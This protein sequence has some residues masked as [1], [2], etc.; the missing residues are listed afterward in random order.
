MFSK[1]KSLCK[2]FYKSRKSVA[3]FVLAMMLA[4]SAF[5]GT[6]IKSEAAYTTSKFYFDLSDFSQYLKDYDNTYFY[7][8]KATSHHAHGY[9]YVD[10]PQSDGSSYRK[11]T[12]PFVLEGN[13]SGS[14]YTAKYVAIF[15]SLPMLCNDTDSRSSFCQVGNI[16][17]FGLRKSDNTQKF[18]Y[19][20]LYS[21]DGINWTI[22]RNTET[23]ATCICTSER[24]GLFSFDPR[25]YYVMAS[26]PIRQVYSGEACYLR[27]LSDAEIKD[28]KNISS[29]G[30][31]DTDTSGNITGGSST[32][33]GGSGSSGSGSSGSNTEEEKGFFAS[34]KESL[35]N[36]LTNIKELPSAVVNVPT[37]MINFWKNFIGSHSIGDIITAIMDAPSNIFNAWKSFFGSHTFLE[38]LNAV[39]NVPATVSNWWKDNLPSVIQ[40]IKDVPSTV[41]GWWSD[42]LPEVL[43]AIVDTPTTVWNWWKEQLPDVV[44]AIIESPKIVLSFWKDFFKEHSFSDILQAIADAPKDILKFW[45]NL[46]GSDSIKDIFKDLLDVPS[47][48]LNFWDD[49]I[50]GFIE[51]V[52]SKFTFIEESKSNIQLII[53]RLASMSNPKPPVITLPF[54]KTVMSKYGVGDIEMTFEW[55]APYHEL[56]MNVESACLYVAFC[57]RNFFDVKNMLNATSGASNVVTRL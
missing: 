40:A 4:F 32:V 46:F 56:L 19:L 51:S 41:S 11:Q 25:D 17:N 12:Y 26:Y 47:N 23:Y 22:Y 6:G 53:D 34:V 49:T 5:M 3:S 24:M 39:K 33:I 16:I 35:V 54:S 9:R 10:I 38:L 15:T 31:E 1:I 42:H 30:G 28:L 36:I 27:N 18:R 29:S 37:T 52:E 14:C 48:L 55:L 45:E 2:K 20:L 21:D 7:I 13:A 57:V 8:F 50:V 44:N 43:Q